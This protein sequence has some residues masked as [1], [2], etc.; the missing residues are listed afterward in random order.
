MTASIVLFRTLPGVENVEIH[1]MMTEKIHTAPPEWLI[2]E[3]SLRLFGI[4]EQDTY[5]TPPEWFLKN[6]DDPQEWEAFAA[7]MR[8]NELVEKLFK[9][10]E[11]LTNDY[12]PGAIPE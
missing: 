9:P 5:F 11:L 4:V 7:W 6:C 10:S 3:L 12:L 8:D 1:Q 2:R